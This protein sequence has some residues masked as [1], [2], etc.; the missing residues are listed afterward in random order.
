MGKVAE[1]KN[2]LK[3]SSF[4]DKMQLTVQERP[5][6]GMTF[7]VERLEEENRT[8]SAD[9]EMIRVTKPEIIDL[10]MNRSRPKRSTKATKMVSEIM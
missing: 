1:E 4:Q 10:P 9:N 8:L 6:H 7:H 5:K 2:E 3:T